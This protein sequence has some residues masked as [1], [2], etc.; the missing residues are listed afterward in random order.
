MVCSLSLQNAT[1][2]FVLFSVKTFPF[3]FLTA[4]KLGS[5]AKMDTNEEKAK[6]NTLTPAQRARKRAADRKFRKSSREKTKSYI[7]H[8][9]KLVEASSTSS[10]GSETV[11]HLMQQARESYD[12]A[13]QLRSALANIIELA[14]SNLQRFSECADKSALATMHVLTSSEEVDDQDGFRSPTENSDKEAMGIVDLPLDVHQFTEKSGSIGLAELLGVSEPLHPKDDGFA[15][16]I[17]KPL[18]PDQMEPKEL[19]SPGLAELLGVSDSFQRKDDEFSSFISKA[20]N[21]DKMEP[22]ITNA[23]DPSL[24]ISNITFAE[25]SYSSYKSVLTKTLERP[26]LNISQP[27]TTNDSQSIWSSLGIIT[28]AAL[29]SSKKIVP[30]LS[31][32]L[33]RAHDENVLIT[34]VVH[35][36]HSVREQDLFDPTWQAIRRIDEQI[37]RPYRTVEKLAMLYVLR[38]QFLVC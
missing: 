13:R 25:E 27:S 9:E 29:S 36:W 26:E 12:Q 17:S 11:Q 5:G 38:L 28:Y 24:S 33:Q 20:P 32:Q 4:L 31:G 18:N 3:I 34:A 21:P 30:S 8:L 15:P 16:F 1:G 10:N 22:E 35:G 6:P 7:A 14:Q 37:L 2:A 23:P 19:Y